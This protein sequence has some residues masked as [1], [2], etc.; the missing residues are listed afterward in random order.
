MRLRWL[1]ITAIVVAAGF[2]V[3]ELIISFMPE[4]MIVGFHWRWK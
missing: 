2:L 4:W 3:Y 1:K